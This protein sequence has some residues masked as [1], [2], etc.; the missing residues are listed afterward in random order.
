MST[1]EERNNIPDESNSAQDIYSWIYCTG[2]SNYIRAC[3]L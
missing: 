1:K 2:I 3:G